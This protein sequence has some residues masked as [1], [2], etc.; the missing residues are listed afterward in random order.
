MDGVAM[1]RKMHRF[2]KPDVDA[3]GTPLERFTPSVFQAP[4]RK[5][6]DQAQVERK[7]F[8]QPG[9]PDG[10]LTMSRESVIEGGA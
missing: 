8:S 3:L 7:E 9:T 1:S 10:P 5:E 4:G 2:F 6:T